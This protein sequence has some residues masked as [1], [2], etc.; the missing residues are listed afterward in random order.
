MRYDKKYFE[1]FLHSE[2]LDELTMQL[3]ANEAS[4]AL[5]EIKSSP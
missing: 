3:K 1:Q 2:S 5:N 4:S